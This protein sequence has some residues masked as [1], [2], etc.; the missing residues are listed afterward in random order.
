MNVWVTWLTL[1][2]FFLISTICRAQENGILSG[3]VK[4]QEGN[5][6]HLATISIPEI[7]TGTTSDTSG[8]YNLSIPS[9]RTLSLQI[10]H[11]NFNPLF[12][13]INVKP[14]ETRN[15]DFVLEE[16]VQM[17]DSIEIA[18]GRDQDFRKQVS[19]TVL[20]PKDINVMPAPFGEIGNL[21]A[22][23]PGVVSNNE[24]SG[25]YSVR[26]GNF[27]ENLIYVNDIPVYRP[28]LI[29]AGEQ[30]GLGFVNP[31]LTENIVFSS[32]GWGP[33]YGDKLS[34]NLNV[35]YREPDHW[36]GSVM[37]GLLGGSLHIEGLSKDKKVSFIG[38]LRHKRTEY[39]LN[40]FETQGEYLPRFTDFQGYL[41]VKPGKADASGQ[42]KTDL[43]ILFAYGHNRYKVVPE[44]RETSFGTFNIPLDLFVAFIGQETLNYNTLQ[45]G[46]K[47]T[48][49]FAERFNSR[50]I[51]S[52]YYT[53][54]REYYDIEAGYRLCDVDKRLGSE[55]FNQCLTLRGIGTN[56]DYGRNRLDGQVLNAEAR[57]ELIIDE[58]QSLKFGIGYSYQHFQDHLHEYS[59]VDSADFITITEVVRSDNE[60]HNQ[61]LTGYVQHE[62]S[63]QGI[64]DFSYGL[65]INYST[66]NQQWLLSPRVRYA[67]APEW[68]H[69]I[70]FRVS[71]GFYQQPPFYRELRR[72]DGSLNTDVKAQSSVHLIAGLDYQFLFW[73]RP[74]KFM[75]EAYYKYLYHVNPYDIDNVKI[76]YYAD[77]DAEAY[78]TGLDLRVSGEFIPGDESWFSLGI[79]S[80][81]ENIR[82]DDR[83]Y[84]PR[85]TDQLVNFNIFFQDH[86]PQFPSYRV[87][88]NFNFASGLPFGPP[89]A[90]NTRNNFRGDSYQ[91][92]DLGFSKIFDF[93]ERE[94]LRSLWIGV[95]V[96]NLTGRANTIT[97]YW[98]RDFNNIYYGVPNALT[99]RFFNIKLM[100]KF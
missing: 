57:N 17:L 32:G 20:H 7:K 9:E 16:N 84:I 49:R 71:A 47:L 38:G 79:L 58:T 5:P 3:Y 29:T 28:F 52:N 6:V 77:N 48:H 89:G 54:E 72:F 94:S 8:F 60:T 98:V 33:E 24:L 55:T 30:E 43:G 73:G 44:S 21:I 53:R 34:S 63:W 61:Q 64:H 82:Q 59:F 35:T 41:S 31:D 2:L 95:E 93:N 69:N 90:I 14:G 56:Y 23:L 92:V 13:T 42:H 39:L 91:R 11:I 62:T 96:L 80:A 86:I 10:N 66:L 1:I 67:L 83:E 36:G 25:T 51:L 46:V 15:F 75:A 87:Y 76:R 37:A 99:T 50:L 40:T 4:D 100:V 65:R 22:T 78:A 74:F 68:Y 26:G 97:Y 88:L 45:T 85:P 70:I 19:V 18:S 27:E 12:L 81:K